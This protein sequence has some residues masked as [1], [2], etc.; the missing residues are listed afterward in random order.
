MC[1]YQLGTL[2]TENVTELVLPPQET[3]YLAAN[4]S[5]DRSWWLLVDDDYMIM[6]TANGRLGVVAPGLYL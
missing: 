4:V 6:M 2:N 5:L 3:I 1:T